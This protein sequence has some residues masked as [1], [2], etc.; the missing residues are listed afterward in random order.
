MSRKSDVKKQQHSSVSGRHKND[1]RYDWLHVQY[2]GYGYTQSEC[3]K[4]YDNQLRGFKNDFYC[5]LNKGL[6]ALDAHHDG[7]SP[8]TTECCNIC[9]NKVVQM[10]LV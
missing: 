2:A 4:K 3:D 9:M 8:S 10:T 6:T 5:L 7:L 1:W